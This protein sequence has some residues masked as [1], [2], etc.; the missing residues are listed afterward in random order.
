MDETIIL[1][2]ENEADDNV[3]TVSDTHKENLP[4][5]TE[6]PGNGNDSSEAVMSE[7][8]V[9]PND[10]TSVIDA[11]NE[12]TDMV[13]L[14]ITSNPIIPHRSRGTLVPP[15][16]RFRPGRSGHRS[17]HQKAFAEAATT[18]V[19]YERRS[20]HQD[21]VGEECA[22]LKIKYKCWEGTDE[23]KDFPHAS[24]LPFGTKRL[25]SHQQN[26]NDHCLL[27]PRKRVVEEKWDVL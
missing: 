5:N 11:G 21:G 14:V 12:S 22:H 26:Q 1:G 19:T 27:C 3:S 20:Y 18:I 4:V 2:E 8:T 13:E 9:N 16:G 24:H 15:R 6:L 25:V 17:S 10:S 23:P 7:D